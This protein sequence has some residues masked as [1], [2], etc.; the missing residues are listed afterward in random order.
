[1]SYITVYCYSLSLSLSLLIVDKGMLRFRIIFQTMIRS[2]RMSLRAPLYDTFAIAR[3]KPAVDL[4]FCL[5]T[6]K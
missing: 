3:M 6:N 4:N 5:S 2:G 1:M